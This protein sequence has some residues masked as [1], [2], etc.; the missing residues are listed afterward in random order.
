MERSKK[1]QGRTALKNWAV[2]WQWV[3]TFKEALPPPPSGVPD[4][5]ESGRK[6]MQG[7]SYM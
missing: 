1:T 7:L 5:I 6:L 2:V 4:S 3:A